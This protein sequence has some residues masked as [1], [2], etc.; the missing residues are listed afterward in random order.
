MTAVGLA[1][2][3]KGAAGTYSVAKLGTRETFIQAGGMYRSLSQFT[4][5]DL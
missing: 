2:I 3:W 5:T 4:K 1:P